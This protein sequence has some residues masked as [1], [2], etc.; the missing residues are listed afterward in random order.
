MQKILEPIIH[1][2]YL[3][4]VIFMGGYILKN[5][6]GNKLYRAFGSF[7]MVLALGDG[8]YL[9]ARMYALLTT[10][11]EE[12]LKILG[13]GR[14]GHEVIFTILVLMLYDIYN[15][16]YSKKKNVPLNRMFYVFSIIRIIII[17]LP[18]NKFFEMVPSTTYAIYRFIPLAIM[19]ALLTLL[20]YLHSDKYG[21]FN[22]KIVSI[23]IFISILL[24]EP[25]MVLKSTLGINTLTVIRTAALVF[26]ILIGLKEVRDNTELSRY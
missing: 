3:A 4:S 22:F 8:V 6:V 25:S 15:L 24:S 16:R 13:W 14:L 7:A 10:G 26:I 17:L 21:D 20:V 12:N 23:A 9:I 5:S 18:G 1:I 11:I 2:M 19:G